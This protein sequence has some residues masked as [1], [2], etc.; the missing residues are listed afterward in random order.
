MVLIS[1][2][3]DFCASLAERVIV[4]ADGG[5]LLDATA[6]EALSKTE[7]LNRAAVDAPQIVR[8]AQALGMEKSPLSIAGFVEE[9]ARWQKDSR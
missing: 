6:E 5:I 1:H 9:Y 3:L 7:L 4:M 8:L 2:D